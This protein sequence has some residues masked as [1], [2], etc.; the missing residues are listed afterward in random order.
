MSDRH[1]FGYFIGGPE[2]GKSR[3]VEMLDNVGVADEFVFSTMNS[4]SIEE[5][6]KDKKTKLKDVDVSKAVYR[7]VKELDHFAYRGHYI[8]E[9]YGNETS[10]EIEQKRI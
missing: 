9:Y 8:Y 10:N 1:Y 3:M 7:K 2:H 4:Y 6:L 5:A